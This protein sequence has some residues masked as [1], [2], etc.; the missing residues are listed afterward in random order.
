M[1]LFVFTLVTTDNLNSVVVEI[2]GW[3]DWI[4][5]DVWQIAGGL[6]VILLDYS[7]HKFWY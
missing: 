5:N 2:Y 7:L 4:C 3:N 6:M 1:P